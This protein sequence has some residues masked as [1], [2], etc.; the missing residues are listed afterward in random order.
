MITASQIL[1]YP[2]KEAILAELFTVVEVAERLNVT[3]RTI[4]RWIKAGMFPNAHKKNPLLQTSPY[5][6][7][8]EDLEKFETLIKNSQVSN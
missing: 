8:L 5:V 6:I 4:T 1:E 7:P 2:K 3:P